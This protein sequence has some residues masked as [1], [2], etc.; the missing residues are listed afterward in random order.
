MNKQEKAVVTVVGKDTVGILAK[1][2]TQVANANGNIIEVT[3][4]V[5]DEFFT[6]IMLVD[7]TAL[8]CPI[9]E[10]EQALKQTLPG[11]EIHVMHENIFNSM[12][13]I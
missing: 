4:S 1:V 12:H 3:Q 5:M 6:M 8:T 2:A 9:Y 7:V 13:S 10:L 11:M